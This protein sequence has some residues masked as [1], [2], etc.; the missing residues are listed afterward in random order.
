[1]KIG[2]DADMKN[3]CVIQR[4]YTQVTIQKHLSEVFLSLRDLHR[5]TN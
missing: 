4:S 1:M 2:F 3:K 5:R